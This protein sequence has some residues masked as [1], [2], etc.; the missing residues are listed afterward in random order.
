[1]SP[2]L[3]VFA[4]NTTTLGLLEHEMYA[5]D[6]LVFDIIEDFECEELNSERSGVF[7]NPER[8]GWVLNS[9]GWQ[10]ELKFLGLI[11]NG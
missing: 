4:I 11:F 8:S 5:E 1:M 3:T 6:G 10:K 9:K 7:L 2:L